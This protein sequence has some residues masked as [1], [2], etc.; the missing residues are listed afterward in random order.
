MNI[1]CIIIDDEF[2]ARVLLK[3]Y[4]D[5][6]PDLEL[7]GSFSSP[8]DAI[9]IIQSGI[10]DVMFLDIQMPD[11]SGID[12]IKTLS[13]K[14]LIV[15]TTAYMEYAIEGYQLDVLDYLLK[16][17]SFERF[18]KTIN[19]VTE[20]LAFTEPTPHNIDNL[21]ELNKPDKSHIII[22]ADHKIHRVKFNQILYI[23]GLREYVSFFCKN[24]KIITL[25]S[26]RRLEDVLPDDMFLRVHKSYIVNIN[27]VKSL[28]GNQLIIEGTEKIIPIGKSYKDN[29]QNRMF[30]N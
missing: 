19:K 29:V 28:Y 24:E 25:E 17:F 21:S 1:K 27:S 20:K 9:S 10:V 30:N 14:P 15:F 7:A 18:L 6:I 11:I 5:K 22:K 12:F 16:P 2:P 3:E 4:V 8:V 13:K 26:L 23:E